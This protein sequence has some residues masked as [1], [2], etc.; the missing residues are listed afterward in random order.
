MNS[1]L[2]VGGLAWATTEETLRTHFSQIGTVVSAVI[3]TDK[4]SGR[5]KGY[6]FVEMSSEQEAAEAVSKLDNS[7]LDGRNIRVSEAKPMVPRDNGMQA[8]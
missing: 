8:S 6:G 5:S 3:I 7:E 4:F 2:F 1:K